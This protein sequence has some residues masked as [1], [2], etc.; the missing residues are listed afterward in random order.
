MGVKMAIDSLIGPN[1][2]GLAQ[3]IGKKY[4]SETKNYKPK[5][6]EKTYILKKNYITPCGVNQY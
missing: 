4:E 1:T 3:R 2:A 5:K 6:E